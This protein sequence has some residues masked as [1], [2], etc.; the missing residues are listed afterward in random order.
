ML[1]E[2]PVEAPPL[3]G[4]RR[5]HRLV[6]GTEFLGEYQGGGFRE[7]KFLIRRSE[8]C[9]SSTWATWCSGA[10]RVRRRLP[11]YTVGP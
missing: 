1:L 2:N 8:G 9:R 4:A 6:E 11:P 7:P 5:V 10:L 3:A